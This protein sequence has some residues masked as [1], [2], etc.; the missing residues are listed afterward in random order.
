MLL[1]IW[2]KTRRKLQPIISNFF[3]QN[4]FVLSRNYFLL[5]KEIDDSVPMRKLNQRK[6]RWI[7]K[8]INSQERSIYRI[9]KTQ[10][11]TPQWTRELYQ[12]Y[13]ES[14]QYPSPNVTFAVDS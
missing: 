6:V 11:I 7:I 12:R 8:E 13:Q 4:V 5:E 3:L 9:A 2:K 1:F 14:A 10:D